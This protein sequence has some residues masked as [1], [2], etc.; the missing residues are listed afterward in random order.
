MSFKLR[1]EIANAHQGNPAE[2]IYLAKQSILN[3]ADYVKFQ[4]YKAHE[5]YPKNEG[6]YSHFKKQ[7]F[8]EKE[9]N[10]IFKQ[11]P[12]NKIICDVFGKDSLKI[13]KDNKIKNFKMHL[14]DINNTPLIQDILKT[15]NKIFFSVS[16]CGL[17]EIIKLKKLINKEK[18][19]KEIILVYGFQ[20]YPT[21][22]KDINFNNLYFYKKIFGKNIKISY[23]DHTAGDSILS[24]MLPLLSLTKEVSYIEKHITR[25]R[26][27][28][29]VDYFS[30]INVEKLADYRNSIALSIKTIKS[31]QFILSANEVKYAKSVKKFPLA[32]N[33]L[34]E[35]SKVKQKDFIFARSKE[36]MFP[37]NFTEFENKTLSKDIKN[38]Q[39]L[40]SSF[41]KKKIG[42]LIIARNNSKR[43]KNKLFLKINGTMV[44]EYLIKRLKSNNLNQN[45]I[46]CTTNKAQDAKLRSIAIK[47]KINV[48]TGPELNVLQ[49]MINA[50]KKFKLD[51]IVRITGD[52]ILID[53]NLMNQALSLHSRT[54]ADYTENKGLP[55]G[56]EVEIFDK[57][58]IF[59]INKY[60][61]NKDLSEY[62]TYYITQNKDKFNTST[63]SIP[64]KLKSKV[65]FSI[66][67]TKDFSLVKK[68]LNK[69]KKNK[70]EYSFTTLELVRFS[71]KF[72]HK[73]K[74]KI[75]DINLEKFKEN[76]RI[77]YFK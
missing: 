45:I 24:Y 50:I 54:N 58:A 11:F 10:F 40:N 9:W 29:K 41:L 53:I 67:S 19:K 22:I 27:L 52:D 23:A 18:Y 8:N 71:K 68:F 39:F 74:K 37:L 66:D 62:L 17:T 34:I 55:S 76:F 12:K 2:A 77:K 42:I 43:L 64:K 69:M 21:N 73:Y 13:C 25:N 46:L 32:N 26:S 63:L 47:N 20:N 16:G 35:G 59:N 51:T 14:S 57:S 15:G 1:S 48:C 75:K 31:K 36:K 6:R 44:I 38:G 28:K 70:K 61:Q 65:S 4:V 30:S 5:L 49:R 72:D 33:D 56:T 3:K 60:G 7:S